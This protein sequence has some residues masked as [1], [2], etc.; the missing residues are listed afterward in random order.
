MKLVETPVKLLRILS[1]SA[2]AVLTASAALAQ[3]PPRRPSEWFGGGGLLVGVPL[4]DFADATD[5][6]LG[7]VGNVVFTP[8]RGPFGIRLQTG[9]LVYGSRKIHP[10]VPGTGGLVT[11]EVTTDNWLLNAGL[12]V[13]LTARSGSVRPY[14]Y[15]LAGLGYFATD[16]SLGDGY[17]DHYWDNTTTNYDD[18]TF[19]WSAGAGLLFPLSRSLALDVGV[20]YVGNGTVSYLA[21]GD[22]QPSAS[23]APPVVVPRRTAANLVTI[24]VG[25]SLGY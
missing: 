11:Q 17:D 16:T 13:Q 6:G 23:G 14:A 9:A 24:T 18:T 4:G 8:G 22:L 21:E 5:E 1:F 12:G 15:A 25:L 20:Q 7:L 3:A 19:A 10:P 2:L